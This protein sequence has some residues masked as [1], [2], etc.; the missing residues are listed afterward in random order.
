MLQQLLEI[1]CGSI[2]QILE[3]EEYEEYEK[4][5]LGKW[6]SFKKMDRGEKQQ[7]ADSKGSVYS[8]TFP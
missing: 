8:L 5:A 6:K 2:L 4:K 7:Q 3:N 1:K